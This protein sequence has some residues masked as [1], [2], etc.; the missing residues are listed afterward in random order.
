MEEL[1]ACK[2]A[3]GKIVSRSPNMHAELQVLSPL[4]PVREVNFL[5]FCKQHAE[6]VW[7]VV[8][9]SVDTI[10]ET[11]SAVHK[12]NKLNAGNVHEDVRLM[13]RKSVVDLHSLTFLVMNGLEASWTC[14]QM[15]INANQSSMSI[16][17]E[18]CIDVDG[19]LVMYAPVN[20]PVMHVV[21]NGGF[22]IIP[23]GSG[24]R[25]RKA[26]G[27]ST[28]GNGCN[29]GAGN[30]VT[31]Q[32]LFIFALGMLWCSIFEALF[33][34]LGCLGGIDP[35]ILFYS[36]RGVLFLH[37]RCSLEGIVSSDPVRGV[38]FLQARYGIRGRSLRMLN[39]SRSWSLV[40]AH[41]V[42]Y[43]VS[44]CDSVGVYY[45]AQHY[46]STPEVVV[47]DAI[48]VG[49]DL[50]CG[51]FLGLHREKVVKKG[52]LSEADINKAL[53]NTLTVQIRL[54]R[55]SLVLLK[56]HGHILPLSHIRPRTVAVIGPNSDVAVTMIA[57]CA[58]KYAWKIHQ[59]GC[60]D[61]GDD[62][63]FNAAIDDSHRAD[64]TIL[65][66]GLDQSIEAKARDMNF[67]L[68]A[69]KSL[70]LRLPSHL[71]VRLYWIYVWWTY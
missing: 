28:N 14:S 44:D 30:G 24:S 19:S 46:T 67:C 13:S 38:L 64:A 50:D 6:G 60:K 7:V 18:T 31:P 1:I 40:F 11:S 16:L 41:S 15:A 51:P 66:M 69:N 10:R 26:N 32:R 37:V 17:Q 54:A 2:K 20:L 61:V 56:N 57:N 42:R 62:K 4:V 43:I 34:A 53:V 63:L 68:D 23:D 47:A 29:N 65:V 35:W 59:Q 3:V 21:I 22:A 5:R 9:V 52:L 58:G 49:L 39:C 25:G 71:E 12:W 27:G 70:C 36:G 48:K 8:N 55:Q 33:F 45:N